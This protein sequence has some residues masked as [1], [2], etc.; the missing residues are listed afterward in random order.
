MY[1]AALYL[2]RNADEAQELLQE[3]FLRAYRF[4]HQFTPG[5]N[6]RAWLMTILHN[7]FKNRYR[8]R[9][10]E[11]QR[12]DFD[13]TITEANSSVNAEALP[14]SPEDIVLAQFLDTEVEEALKSLP[15]EFLEVIVLVDIHEL[16]YE[17]AAAAIG[18]PVGTIRSRLSRGRRLLEAAL[19]QYAKERGYGRRGSY[20]L[21]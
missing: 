17:E 15:V 5:T 11:Q 19:R 12:V 7:T 3:T 4:W 14:T 6:C 13:D 8:D 10:R 9:Y 18:C 16:T 21:R 1:T 20:A 2:T